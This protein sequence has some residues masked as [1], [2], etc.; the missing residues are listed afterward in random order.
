MAL[1]H[2]VTLARDERIT[3][4]A[5]LRQRLTQEGHESQA[6]RDALVYWANRE[7]VFASRA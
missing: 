2:A 3:R 7:R 1:R 4:V 6:V 5:V